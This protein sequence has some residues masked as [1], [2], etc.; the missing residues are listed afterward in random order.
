MCTH[1][2]ASPPRCA[3]SSICKLTCMHTLRTW[4]MGPLP[5]PQPSYPALAWNL[6]PVLILKLPRV[7]IEAGTGH[8]HLE[9]ARG[10]PVHRHC[11][12]WTI[13]P[14]SMTPWSA[15]NPCQDRRKGT[16]APAS[17]WCKLPSSLSLLG[18]QGPACLAHLPQSQPAQGESRPQLMNHLQAGLSRSQV[19][20]GGCSQGKGMPA[21]AQG[22]SHPQK[23]DGGGASRSSPRPRCSLWLFIPM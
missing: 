21:L 10:A 15:E 9:V 7:M 18:P 14:K 3:N 1:K 11:H 4:Q 12:V 16:G 8:T 17:E 13:S 6:T 5:P 2:D 19:G 20:K 22:F 23:G